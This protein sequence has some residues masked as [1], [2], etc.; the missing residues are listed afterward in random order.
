MR[1]IIFS[2]VACPAVQYFPTLSHKRLDFRGKKFPEHKICVSIFSTNFIWNICYSTKISARY[3]KKFVLI[4]MWSTVFVARF[5]WNLNFL[6]I[7]SKKISNIEF[8]E[9]PSSWSR[10]VPYGH[11]D[12][13]K[14]IVTFFRNFA[15][16]PQN[17]QISVNLLYEPKVLWCNLQSNEEHRSAVCR[18]RPAPIA[19]VPSPFNVSI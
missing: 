1:R 18:R 19:D 12:M 4:F 9:N 15:N 14:L 8:H 10:V 13:I 3:N 16:A 17:L 7:C 11:T 5:E 6:D 2:S